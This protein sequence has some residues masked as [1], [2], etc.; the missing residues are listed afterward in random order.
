MSQQ[1]QHISEEEQLLLRHV[2]SKLHSMMGIPIEISYMLIM[3]SFNNLNDTN[4]NLE[5]NAKCLWMAS[6]IPIDECRQALQASN[7]DTSKAI[8]IVC[9]SKHKDK[10]ISTEAFIERSTNYVNKFMKKNIMKK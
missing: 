10:N 9:A 4:V 1:Q 6:G 7:N 5:L 2:A 3:H 8:A